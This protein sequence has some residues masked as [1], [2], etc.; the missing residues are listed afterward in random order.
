MKTRHWLISLVTIIGLTWLALSPTA[1]QNTVVSSLLGDA[2]P[3]PD[4]AVF[5]DVGEKKRAFFDYLQPM[6]DANNRRVLQDR[7]KL[8]MLIG[9]PADDL[10]R[11]EQSFI[12]ERVERYRVDQNL[13]HDD[14]IQ[15]LMKRLDEV[16]VSLALA[17][18]AMES[19]WGTSRF[20]RE[21]NN[22][23]GQWCYR[24]GCG[25]I[26]ARRGEGQTHEVARFTNV[27]AAVA[28]YLRN[29]NS[30]PAYNDL[31]TARAVL[32]TENQPITGH[33]MAAHL[34]R[35]SERGSAY[36]EE[37]QSMIRINKLAAR[38][39]PNQI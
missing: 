33:A 35:Y 2:N 13:A 9:K 19:A 23:F 36:V 25:I 20:A 3:L 29:I 32:R 38:D 31:R 10:A 16:P 17:Q 34:L 12:D 5:T 27:D 4:F 21:G 11:S 26:P 28:S 18:A 30:H 6:V 22:L 39:M 24:A 14:Q 8:A 15:E 7:Q 37:I 1:R